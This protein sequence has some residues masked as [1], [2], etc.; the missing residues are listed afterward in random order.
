MEEQS[1]LKAGATWELPLADALRDYESYLPVK[2]MQTV[3]SHGA[4]AWGV[5]VRRE[6]VP[7]RLRL[8]Q[9]LH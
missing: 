4:Q 8:W 2:G 3:G 1:C 9:A 5:I 7:L 6:H